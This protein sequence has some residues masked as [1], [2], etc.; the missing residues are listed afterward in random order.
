M[1]SFNVSRRWG[2]KYTE[3]F[4]HHAPNVTLRC[5][6]AGDHDSLDHKLTLS[7]GELTSILGEAKVPLFAAPT[8]ICFDLT[9]FPIPHLTS[10]WPRCA[11]SKF[12]SAPQL[13]KSSS[14]GWQ[15]WGS[16]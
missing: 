3:L 4:T 15:H 9:F 10:A 8:K 7:R 1:K 14:G 16:V 13:M 12:S 5:L 6:D 11:R 2:Q